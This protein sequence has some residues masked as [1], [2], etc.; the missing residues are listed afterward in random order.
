M[1]I[2]RE[3]RYDKS[4]SQGYRYASKAPRNIV[5]FRFVM[6]C[7]LMDTRDGFLKFYPE[8]TPHGTEATS[9]SKSIL[10]GLSF[11]CV[12]GLSKH[13][14]RVFKTHGINTSHRPYNTLRIPI[15]PPKESLVIYIWL[16][17]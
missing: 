6:F 3:E 5:N 14:T 16:G 10:V 1:N 8:V 13:L 11:V 7:W 9:E 2:R 17:G 15:D 12:S 4:L